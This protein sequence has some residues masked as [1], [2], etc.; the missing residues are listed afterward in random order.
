VR[1]RV[2]IVEAGVCLS[3]ARM[4]QYNAIGGTPSGFDRGDIA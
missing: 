2:L 3:L 1:V 4:R